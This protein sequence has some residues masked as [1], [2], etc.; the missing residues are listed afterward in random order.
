MAGLGSSV[1]VAGF[2]MLVGLP[3]AFVCGLL[4]TLI[5]PAVSPLCGVVMLPIQCATR[6]VWWVAVVGERMSPH[7]LANA[8][9]WVVWGVFLVVLHRSARIHT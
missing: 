7:G 8:L 3:L 9:L 1:P 6:W 2:V 4:I 5:G